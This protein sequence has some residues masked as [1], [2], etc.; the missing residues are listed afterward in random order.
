MRAFKTAYWLTVFSFLM[1]SSVAAAADCPPECD[2]PE[3]TE[4][5]KLKNR[6]ASPALSPPMTVSKFLLHF[7]DPSTKPAVCE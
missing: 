7:P 4:I 6:T 2:R 5:N 1:V 3:H